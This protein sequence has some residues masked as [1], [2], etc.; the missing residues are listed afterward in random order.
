MVCWH[1]DAWWWWSRCSCWEIEREGKK[2][3]EWMI[4]L[5]SFGECQSSCT[6]NR[7]LRE[8]AS[9]HL[10]SLDR[11]WSE[12]E[13]EMCEGESD[14]LLDLLWMLCDI[15]NM[16]W[17]ICGREDCSVYGMN[18]LDGET[19]WCWICRQEWQNRWPQSRSWTG[20]RRMNEQR[21]QIN[22]VSR[23]L[24]FCASN[25][26]ISDCIWNE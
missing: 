10:R 5:D 24:L 20:S 25:P 17:W 4:V 23:I 6:V 21:A 7:W 14:V 11:A 2:V 15:E 1:A 9:C 18:D 22:F 16:W 13:N 12:R 19:Y 3:R 26:D 8:I